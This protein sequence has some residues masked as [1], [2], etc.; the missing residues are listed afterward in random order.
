MKE[1][2]KSLPLP[3][4]FPQTPASAISASFLCWS[5]FSLSLMTAKISSFLSCPGTDPPEIPFATIDF[6]PLRASGRTF[7]L[8]KT[9]V[10][11]FPS[12]FPFLR[13]SWSPPPFWSRRSKIPPTSRRSRSSPPGR[14]LSHRFLAP[15]SVLFE[16]MSKCP[17]FS[18]E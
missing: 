6:P 3:S 1:R 11:L 8:W 9:V 4:F 16:H 7:S 10:F 13:P 12:H 2:F 18:R 17:F 15:H 5:F 14:W